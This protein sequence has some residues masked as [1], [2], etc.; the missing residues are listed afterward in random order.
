MIY[1]F[2]KNSINFTDSK[3]DAL[4]ILRHTELLSINSGAKRTRS[5][6]FGSLAS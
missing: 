5:K 3:P 2:I 4:T 6:E 1:F